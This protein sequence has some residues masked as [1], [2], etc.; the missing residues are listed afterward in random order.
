VVKHTDRFDVVKGHAHRFLIR[1][2]AH[3][4]RLKRLGRCTV[5]RRTNKYLVLQTAIK[6][7]V[8]RP[9]VTSPNGGTVTAGAVTRVMWKVSSSVSRGYFQVILK[10]A[11]TGAATALTAPQG[12]SAHRG[13]TSYS[14]PWT[15]T[16]PAGGYRVWV[17][18]CNSDG[19]TISEDS[20]DGLLSV[21]LAETPA[22]APTP[23]V[24]PT[25]SATPTPAPTPTATASATPTPVPTPTATASA[26]PTPTATASATPTPTPTPT[27]TASATPT[28]TPTPT[29]TASATPTPTPTPT[30][31][32][33][34][35]PVTQYGANGSDNLDDTSAVKAALAANDGTGKI[36]SFPAGT[37]VLSGRI[38]VPSNST[39][40][41]A[42][43]AQSWLKGEVTFG[44]SV[45]MRDL[46][47]GDAGRMFRATDYGT[48]S[49]STF[50]RCHFRGGGGAWM[51]HQVIGLGFRANVTN[52]L[53]KDC[54]VECNLGTEDAGYTND[55]NNLGIYNT[56]NAQVTGVT[57]EGCHVGVF[58]GVRSGCPRMGLECYTVQKSEGGSGKGWQNVTVRD[59]IFEVCDLHGIDLAD[60][61]DGRANGALIEGCLIK[62]AGARQV[63]YGS[64]IDVE[65]AT[66][67]V[68]RNNTFWHAWQQTIMFAH[69][70][71]TGP[72]TI[73]T[74]NTFDLDV[75]NGI[76]YTVYQAFHISGDGIQV[77][78]NTINFTKGPAA[79]V[80]QFNT[81]SNC[82]VTG[83]TITKGTKA[84][85]VLYN[86]NTNNVYT[87][88]VLK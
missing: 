33:T 75:D 32:A 29:A 71:E 31:T 7:S 10:D 36:V 85:S 63:M 18:Y 87:P 34:S 61:V 39:L 78:N 4:I 14:A 86:T 82:T 21:T 43:M 65:C 3:K 2:G 40:V 6:A 52:V 79:Q 41:G 19:Q 20:S 55:Y 53:F 46:K 74:G 37:Y 54:E 68:I 66:G 47:I 22:P 81:S 83:N 50:E 56:T 42:G 35:V 70:H 58:N 8:C 23:T 59:C 44:S 15:V 26:T 28:P 5:V 1:H 24:T 9:T 49:D 69:I 76:P 73:I 11:V 62:G 30:A 45:V 13:W 67:V 27:A 16:Q 77:T 17:R 80:F 64:D 48:S 25:P 84:F 88:N 38:D 60:A 12:V 51:G 57:F 72:G